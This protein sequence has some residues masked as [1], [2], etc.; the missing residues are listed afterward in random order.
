MRMHCLSLGLWNVFNAHQ[1]QCLGR[2]PRRTFPGSQ[3]CSYRLRCYSLLSELTGVLD[4]VV[5]SVERLKGNAD[6]EMQKEEVGLALISRKLLPQ[7]SN[8]FHHLLLT[9]YEDIVERAEFQG[10]QHSI[11]CTK[12]RKSL[13]HWYL[14]QSPPK[15]KTPWS[16]ES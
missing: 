16:L 15:K 13:Q 8:F 3:S 10:H 7:I 1:Q 4:L 2:I 14:P 11:S 6:V 12:L 5:A 9:R